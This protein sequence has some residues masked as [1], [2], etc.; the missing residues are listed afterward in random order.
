MAIL[1]NNIDWMAII[2]YGLFILLVI[3]MIT[4]AILQSEDAR[5][6]AH[7]KLICIDKPN[8]TLFINGEC[9]CEIDNEQINETYTNITN[10][11]L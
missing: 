7:C 10:D 6:R 4:T 11:K 3:M 5:E 9:W 8:T 2:A 1:K